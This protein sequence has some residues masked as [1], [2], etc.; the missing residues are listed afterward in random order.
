[1]LSLQKRF[2]LIELLVVIAIIAIL[3]AILLP[4]LQKARDRAKATQCLNQ[5]KQIYQHWFNYA[6]EHRE[7]LLPDYIKKGNHPENSHEYWAYYMNNWVQ[8]VFLLNEKKYLY[9]LRYT[10]LFHCPLDST[11][12]I[13]LATMQ[14]VTGQTSF[15][16]VMLYASIGY[17]AN[18]GHNGR[19]FK[20]NIQKLSGFQKNV[21]QTIIF[22]D[23]WKSASISIAQGT[24]KAGKRQLI[25]GEDLDTGIA[26]SHG[27]GFNASYADGSIRNSSFVYVNDDTKNNLAVWNTQNPLSQYKRQ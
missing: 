22:G 21:S 16:R 11:R 23:S 25:N 5:H 24:G 14:K 13:E 8:P 17:N 9:W 7:Y 6:S 26:A 19:N 18:L 3:A 4:A 1:M 10:S 15:N 27:K 20:Q 2:T 12:S